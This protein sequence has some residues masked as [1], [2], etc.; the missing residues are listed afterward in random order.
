LSSDP[1]KT[2]EALQWRSLKLSS[3]NPQGS[4]AVRRNIAEL[5]SED[6]LPEHVVTT[7]GTTGANMTVLLSLVQVGDHVISVYP[8]YPQLL[9]LPKRLG[10][11]LS[12]WKLDPSKGWRADVEELRKL[13]KPS[14]KLIILNTP[15]N[16]T[17]KQ[18]WDS[19]H[20]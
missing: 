15:G 18:A 1:A 20:L 7:T 3:H 4:D 5:Y 10:C 13:I 14:T 12:L 2:E 11:E 9:G 6:V 17:G 19:L 8:V 16:P